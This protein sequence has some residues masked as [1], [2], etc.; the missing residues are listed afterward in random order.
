VV[1]PLRVI[2]EA[3]QR[4]LLGDLGEQ[5]QRG[6]PYQEPVGRGAGA[7]A[8]HR[9]E[10]VALRTGQPAEPVQHRRAQLVQAGISQLHLRLDADGPRDVPVGGPVGQ[11]TKQR[12][13]ARARLAP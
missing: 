3:D 5:R 11:V 12:A 10:R 1:E 9:R 2:D 6:Q 4:L 7:A 8:E 13:L